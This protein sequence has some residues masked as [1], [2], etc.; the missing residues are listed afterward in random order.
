MASSEPAPVDYSNRAIGM[1]LLPVFAY[2]FWIYTYL[3]ITDA[4]HGAASVDYSGK[5]VFI[6]PYALVAGLIY[7]IFGENAAKF[8]GPTSKPSVT[9]WSVLIMSCIL[10]GFADHYLKAFLIAHGYAIV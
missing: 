10:G 3:P 7:L 9:G 6:Q 8:M 2:C 5:F 1:I 4:M